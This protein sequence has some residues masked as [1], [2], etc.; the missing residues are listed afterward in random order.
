MGRPAPTQS[1]A[2]CNGR[3]G[4]LVDHPRQQRCSHTQG[5][6]QARTLRSACGHDTPAPA[7][8]V[9]AVWIETFLGPPRGRL[10]GGRRC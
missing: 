5:A 4:G 7:G 2:C 8:A 3:G 6:S 10:V 9:A 1:S